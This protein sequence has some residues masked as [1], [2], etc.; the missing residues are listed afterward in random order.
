M[1]VLILW[2][3]QRGIVVLVKVLHPLACDDL[4]HLKEVGVLQPL[5]N[6]DFSHQLEGH[7]PVPAVVQPHLLER[8]LPARVL[9]HGAVHLPVC[10]FPNLLEALV[11][12]K[13]PGHVLPLAVDRSVIFGRRRRRGGHHPGSG[14]MT[15]ANKT[16]TSTSSTATSV[17]RRILH[18]VVERLWDVRNRCRDHGR[19]RRHGCLSFFCFFF[20]FS[21]SAATV[22]QCTGC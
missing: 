22:M 11:V 7:P 18:S 15:N 6:L 20:F 2:G 17:M 10:A 1:L 12:V 4:E 8:H 9:A 16:S 19:R 14:G 13:R 3:R 5:Q 21:S